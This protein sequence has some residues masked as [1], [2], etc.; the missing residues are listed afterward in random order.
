MLNLNNKKLIMIALSV[1]AL[2][3]IYANAETTSDS[4]CF[5]FKHNKLID[6]KSCQI[7]DYQTLGSGYAIEYSIQD[8]GTFE[9][10][11]GLDKQKMQEYRQLNDEDAIRQ[12]RLRSNYKII[13]LGNA[14][15]FSD[16]KH[17]SCIKQVNS[18]FEIC[19]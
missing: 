12:I 18:H 14:N 3:S 1:L 10:Y 5:I 8:Y 2:C 6:K 4:Q 7:T 13:K 17:L 15:K 16:K 9:H 11:G 19:S